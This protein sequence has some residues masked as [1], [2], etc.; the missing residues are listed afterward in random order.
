MA[1]IFIL[2]KWISAYSDRTK[3]ER[4]ADPLAG[5]NYRKRLSPGKRRRRVAHEGRP[6]YD[7][8][9]VTHRWKFTRTGGV[10]QVQIE[11]GDDIAH[12]PELDQKLWVALAMPCDGSELDPKTAAVLDRDKDGRIRAPEVCEA[13]RFAV[14]ALV[15]PK[16]LFKKGDS[17]ALSSLRE[18]PLKSAATRILENLGK[19]G[20]DRITLADVADTAKI[21]AATQFNGDGIIPADAADDGDLRKV[22]EEIIAAH[23]SLVDRS[24]KPGVDQAKVDLFFD[25]VK[26]YVA[27]AGEDGGA[28]RLP[29]GE[30]TPA[31]GEAVRAVRAKV[32]DYFTRCR[33]A[34]LD[35]RAATLLLGAEADLAAL[36]AREL[37]AGTREVAQLPLSKVEGGRAL[38]LGDGVNPAWAQAM[39][40]L[41]RA[42]VKPI[43]GAKQALAEADWSQLL[44]RLAGFDAWQA[45]KPVTLVEPLGLAR[46]RELD[47][48]DGRAKISALVAKDQALAEE[49]AAIADVERL[50]LLQRDFVRLLQNFV[51]FGEFYGRKGALFQAG[52]LFLDG[53]SCD[54]CMRVADA[55]KHAQLA[56]LASTFLAYCDCTRSGG[57]K[58]TIV[59]AFTDGD[60]DNLIV[61]RNGIFYDRQ[62]RDW[63]ATITKLVPNPISVRQAFWAPYKKLVRMIEEQ[64]GKR[65]A[66]ADAEADA[67]L[68]KV[69]EDTTSVDKEKPRGKPPDTKIDVGTVAAI[70]VAVGGIGAMVTGVLTAFFG[71]GLWMPLGLIAVFLLISGPSMLLAYLKLRQRNLGPLLDASG[72]AI[73]GR[74]RINVPFGAALTAVPALPAG[75]QRSMKDPYAEKR[76]PWRLYITLLLL[77][78]T[79]FAWYVGRLDRWLPDLVKR[80]TVI[81]PLDPE[82]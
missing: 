41:D 46:L 77:L 10:D 62:G 21:F 55:G 8:S 43:L 24:G 64:V 36:S 72:W 13:A 5:D 19:K 68:K 44:A 33:L 53:R 26:A 9:I 37:S 56:S 28:D 25:Q 82:K 31:A 54:L 3:L 34:A 58:M 20:A 51:N 11:T 40:N 71:L 76:R 49:S 39:A 47:G 70:G 27:W 15:D 2:K 17:L 35:G 65:A 63:D 50:L 38:P 16:E 12:L 42:A 30:A 66:A 6:A 80:A 69:A 67:K 22:I 29:L 61:G 57:Q 74:A 73:N 75:A 18:G 7:S 32:D 23:G 1:L 81:G 60:S 14:A 79:A 4:V 52:T 59:A 48:G 45:K 78:A